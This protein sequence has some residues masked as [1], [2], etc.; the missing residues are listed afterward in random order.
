MTKIFSWGRGKARLRNIAL[1]CAA[2]PLPFAF[3]VSPT[4]QGTTGAPPQM[5]GMRGRKSRNIEVVQVIFHFGAFQF[6]ERTCFTSSQG[7][8]ISK[9]RFFPSLRG[10]ALN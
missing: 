5:R 1:P 8:L 4:P 3:V 9:A 2:Y 10:A 6:R 7:A